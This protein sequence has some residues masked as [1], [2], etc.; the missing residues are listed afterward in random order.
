MFDEEEPNVLFPF[1]SFH[2]Q[3]NELEDREKQHDTPLSL[4]PQLMDRG[5]ILRRNH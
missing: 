3:P 1:F 5:E 2:P 4:S